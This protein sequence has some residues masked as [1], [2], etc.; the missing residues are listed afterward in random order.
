M[1]LSPHGFI[2]IAPRALVHLLKHMWPSLHNDFREHC[3]SK[4]SMTLLY[5]FYKSGVNTH[6]TF[7]S[8]HHNCCIIAE[9]VSLYY[10]YISSA[11]HISALIYI[12]VICC[13]NPQVKQ[14]SC[15]LPRLNPLIRAEGVGGMSV[16]WTEP[17][18]VREESRSESGAIL[19]IKLVG[20][21]HKLCVLMNEPVSPLKGQ[22][23][24][25]HLHLV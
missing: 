18:Q 17:W 10:Y 9:K 5:I 11:F 8:I 12:W 25:P 3:H 15:C 22:A 2:P 16:G 13:V 7:K 20:E 1:V 6:H 21:N 19:S 23:C 4:S 14:S 24:E